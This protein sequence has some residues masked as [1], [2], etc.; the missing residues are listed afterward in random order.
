MGRIGKWIKA[1]IDKYIIGTVE[2]RLKYNQTC[3]MYAE[4]GSD[5]P[6]IEK[7]RVAL[8]SVDGTGNF[9]AVGVLIQSQ[10]AKPGEKFL[11]SRNDKG[12]VKAIIKLLEDGKI[13]TYAPEQVTFT[14]D[15]KVIVKVKENIE[16]T[17]DKDIN[18]KGKNIKLEG[19]IKVTGG[20]FEAKGSATPT[21]TGCLCAIPVCPFTGSPHTG[22]KSSGN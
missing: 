12:E 10:G 16:V 13:E 18:T 5:C 1:E 9:V 17:C 14:A 11:Y 15:K 20:T 22:E 6:P 21:G 7:D 8:L 4:S 2:S 3:D 19:N